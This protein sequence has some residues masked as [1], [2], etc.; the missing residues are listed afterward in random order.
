MNEL[1]DVA[2]YWRRWSDPR[3][4][5]LV[6]HNNDLN[7]LEGIRVENVEEIGP[8]WDRAL[9]AD[10]PI[11]ID[12]VVNSDIPPI[13][14][15]VQWKQ[16][17]AVM[18]ASWAAIRRRRGCPPSGQAGAARLGPGPGLKRESPRAMDAK[19]LEQRRDAVQLVDVRWP[20]EW[21]AGH[22]DGAVH[23]PVDELDDRLDGLD[24]SQPVVTVCRTGSRS[25]AAART[26]EADGFQAE[27]LDG[28]MLA[29]E[30]AGLSL[31]AD[32]GSPGRVAEPEPPT[33]DRAEEQQRLHSD[34][35]SLIFEVQEHFGD[36]EPSE[37][38]IREYLRERL[39]REG[40]SP[41]EA[42]EAM[43][44]IMEGEGSDPSD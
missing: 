32:D 34:Y 37:E 41:E 5:V 23:I 28:G 15:H 33:D 29:W 11:L 43:A 36:H 27:S 8:A 12:A 31:V 7:Q 14:P 4:V 44:R 17:R 24:R 38:E 40:H 6:P 42:D 3:L 9:G 1:L 2:K 30:Q 26:L 39:I 19:A 16:A 10:H 35:M 22:I 20:N 18:K 25:T 21:D 13:P